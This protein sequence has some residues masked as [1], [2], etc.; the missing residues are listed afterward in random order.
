MADCFRLMRLQRLS[1]EA[2]GC[3][4]AAALQIGVERRRRVPSRAE[5]LSKTCLKT[6]F[7]TAEK[8]RELGSVPSHLFYCNPRVLGLKH[9]GRALNGWSVPRKSLNFCLPLG[10][11]FVPLRWSRKAGPW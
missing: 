1:A 4:G 5:W 7:A 9:T 6:K 10:P 3:G 11:L 8:T 2:T